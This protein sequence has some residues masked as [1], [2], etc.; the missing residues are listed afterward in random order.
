M[1]PLGFQPAP[2]ALEWRQVGAVVKAG[3]GLRFIGVQR[4]DG[5]V[6]ESGDAVADQVYA[7]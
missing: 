1:D 5:L 7:N 3:A 4:V 2:K 6:T